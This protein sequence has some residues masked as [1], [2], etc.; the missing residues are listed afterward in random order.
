MTKASFIRALGLYGI[1]AVGAWFTVEE[2][3]FR[4]AALIV[5]G[6]TALKTTLAWLG[7]ER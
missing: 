7:R 4:T 1:L 5:I 6:G 3:R 2:P